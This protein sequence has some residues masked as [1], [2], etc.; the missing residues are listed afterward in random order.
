MTVQEKVIEHGAK[1][2]CAPTTVPNA[3]DA[4]LDGGQLRI[5]TNVTELHHMFVKSRPGIEVGSYV[6]VT[7]SDT[8]VLM[9]PPSEATFSSCR[10]LAESASRPLNL[11][12]G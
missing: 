10:F 3:G 9:T 5:E 2:S 1:F 4:V 11:R 6:L 8:G 7:V 12:H